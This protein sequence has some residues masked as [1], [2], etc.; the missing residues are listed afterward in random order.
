M[1]VAFGA[2]PG[3]LLAAVVSGLLALSAHLT[4]DDLPALAIASL[5]LA[6]PCATA[7]GCGVAAALRGRSDAS[8]LPGARTD[9]AGRGRPPS[10]S[11]A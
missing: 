5:F 3:L 9:S 6:A 7:L 1:V 2:L 10:A 8:D 11:L 4:G